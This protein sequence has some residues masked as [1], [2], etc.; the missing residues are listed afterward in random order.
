MATK[1]KVKAAAVSVQVPQTRDDCAAMI[2]ALG[3]A[4]R[5]LAG[6]VSAMNDAIAEVTDYAAPEI[7]AM[8]KTVADL[9][10]G[11]QTFAEANRATLTDGNRVKTANLVTGEVAWRQRPPSVGIRG[12]DTVIETLK[13]LG[14]GRFVRTK[15]E[16]NKDAILNEPKAVSGVAGITLN[17]GIEDFIVTPFEQEVTGA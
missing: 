4:Q 13:R 16:I 9:V 15:E 6:R 11:I 10:E 2:R 12:A 1:S 5:V 17:T 8:K 14:L 3:D 7:E